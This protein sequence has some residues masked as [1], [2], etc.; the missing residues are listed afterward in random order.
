M[1][2]VIEPGKYVVAVSGGIDSMVLLD[3]LAKRKDLELVIA[4]FDHGIRPDSAED[5]KLVQSIAK[6]YGLKFEYQEGHLGE[7]AS[8]EQARSARY[9]FLHAVCSAHNARA[10]ITAHHQDDLI[11]TAL[12]NM[13]RGTGRKGLTSLSSGPHICR[14]LLHITKSQIKA[15]AAQHAIRWREDST[16]SDT[17]YARNYIRSSLI[18]K[19]TPS[20]KEHLLDIITNLQSKNYE[21]DLEIAKLLQLKN[22]NNTRLKKHTIIMMPHTVACESVAAWLRLNGI[23]D[24]D[25]NLIERVVVA[26]K[27]YKAGRKADL[28]KGT[29]VVISDDF[30]EIKSIAKR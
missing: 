9:E 29:Y 4:H 30:A 3:V 16:N 5:R 22:I 25:R 12:L 14:P 1:E 24:F 28:I 6:E 11:E 20:Q 27:T 26:I 2:L 23:R 8:E 15:Y 17:K 21:I 10:V 7:T 13:L 19:L 18:P